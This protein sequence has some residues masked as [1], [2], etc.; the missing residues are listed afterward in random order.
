MPNFESNRIGYKRELDKNDK[1][2]KAIVSFLNYNGGG[3]IL[4]DVVDD[5]TVYG[6]SDSAG[7]QR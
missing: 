7:D 5:G 6:V 1:L 3:V 2:E 4:V